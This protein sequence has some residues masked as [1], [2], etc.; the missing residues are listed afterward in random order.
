M[1]AKRD[2]YE[3]LGVGKEADTAAIKK[4][5]KKAALKFHPDRNPDNPEAEEKFKELG[6]VLPL[7]QLVITLSNTHHGTEN[8]CYIHQDI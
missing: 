4:A 6:Y 8:G 7:L 3:V 5:F 2:Y 1:T